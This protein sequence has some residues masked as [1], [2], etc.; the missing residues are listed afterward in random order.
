MS[1]EAQK[2][3]VVFAREIAGIVG[4]SVTPIDLDAIREAVQ[5][6]LDRLRAENAT[7]RKRAKFWKGECAERADALDIVAPDSGRVRRQNQCDW[8][9]S[10]EQ[11]VPRGDEDDPRCPKCGGA[12]A[13][14][15]D[16]IDRD[17]LA[18]LMTMPEEP[19]P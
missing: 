17:D 19:K 11:L 3:L 9:G 4:A 16:W 1:D 2:W 12:D 10:M 6:E 14:V 15:S 13:I 7:E 5:A 8:R 18:R